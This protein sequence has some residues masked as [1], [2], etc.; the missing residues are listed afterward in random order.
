M[1]DLE[2]KSEGYFFPKKEEKDI[3]SII[4]SVTFYL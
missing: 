3:N 1:V 4:T 2:H